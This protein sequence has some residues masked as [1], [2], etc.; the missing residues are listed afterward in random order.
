MMKKEKLIY[1]A[2]S[3]I[4]AAA[5]AALT[6]LFYPLS[7]GLSQLRVSE[8]L[9]ILPYFTPAAVPGLFLGCIVANIFGGFGLLDIV[10]GSLAT[11]IAAYATYKIKN[12]WL[13]PL[14]AVLA[15]AVIVGAEL[16]YLMNVPFWQAVLGV[17]AGQ[18]VSCYVIGM[19]LLFALEKLQQKWNL[20]GT[21]RRNLV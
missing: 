18:A 10:C 11:L 7:Y 14:P 12:K 17:G 6:L 4:I 3:G 16:A 15:N 13:A 21:I 9:C 19:P 2:Q 1:L 5:Y 20:F 8:G